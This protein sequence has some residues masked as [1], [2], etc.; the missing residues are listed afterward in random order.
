MDIDTKPVNRISPIYIAGQNEL[1]YH[2]V[3]KSLEAGNHKSA[4]QTPLTHPQS[5]LN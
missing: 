2:P 5:V 3:T 1:K 4:F